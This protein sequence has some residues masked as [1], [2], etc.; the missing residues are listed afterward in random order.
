MCLMQIKLRLI[1]GTLFKMNEDF[2]LE[3]LS[4]TKIY[5]DRILHLL[6]A[7]ELSSFFGY[8]LEFGV[9]KGRTI[10]C[11]S[12]AYPKEKF[13]G[14]DSFNGLPEPWYLSQDKASVTPKKWFALDK[15]PEVSNTVK[16][17][18]GL[19]EN[20]IPEWL[21]CHSGLVSFIHVDCDLYSSTKTILTLLNDRIVE[22]TVLVFDELINTP[23]NEYGN[24]REGEWKALNEWCDQYYRE[25]E[26]IS[27]T[28]SCQ[29]TIKVLR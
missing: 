7:A 8:S 13:W 29:V 24:W 25:I 15:V 28:T 11:L 9:Y 6:D 23:E 27:R 3:D 16:L 21:E 22:G 12:Y 19:F 17:E 18:I 4:K 10:N 1:S 2:F 5:K 26:I 20:T 14:F